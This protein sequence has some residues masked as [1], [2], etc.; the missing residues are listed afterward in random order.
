MNRESIMAELDNERFWGSYDD[1]EKEGLGDDIVI[2][3]N[4]DVVPFFNQ[5]YRIDRTI[6]SICHSGWAKGQF[7]LQDVSVSKGDI[8]IL[9][10]DGL[11]TFTETSPDYR[12]TTIV[13]SNQ[14]AASLRQSKSLKLQLRFVQRPVVQLTDSE[15]KM[16]MTFFDQVRYIINSH[17]E[18]KQKLIAQI[19]GTMFFVFLDFQSVREHPNTEKS[20]AEQI[21][22][23]FIVLAIDHHREAREVIWYADKLC[24]TPGY[25]AS[26]V[27][28]ITGKSANDWINQYTILDAKALLK[29]ERHL[30]MQDISECLGFSDQA[31]FCKFFKKQVGM[32]P[33]AYRDTI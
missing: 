4:I 33:S 15:Y 21:F 16:S 24:M 30:T 10:P 14:F 28:R 2:F 20:R 7:N 23:Q 9:L 25:L 12:V 29:T 11:L 31:V 18:N 22:E 8:A 1:L 13:M 19:L 32:T 26:I 6:I 27:K 5:P 17:F 3:D